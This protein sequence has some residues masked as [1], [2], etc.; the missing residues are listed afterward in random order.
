MKNTETTEM[1]W[2]VRTQWL[3]NTQKNRT[4]KKTEIAS[5]ASFN[6]YALLSARFTKRTLYPSARFSIPSAYFCRHF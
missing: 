4:F 1:I 6:E 2:K 3:E 5:G